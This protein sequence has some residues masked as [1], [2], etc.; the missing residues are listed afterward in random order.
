[1]TVSR[2][3]ETAPCLPEADTPGGRVRGAARQGAQAFLGIPYG[4]STAGEGRFCPP[5]PA[6][7]WAGT[8]EA[9]THGPSAPQLPNADYADAIMSWYGAIRDL[10]EDCLRLNVFTPACDTARR[11]V[12]VWLH[13]GGWTQ[14]ASTA[15]GFDG[16]ALAAAGDVVVVSLNHRLGVFGFLRLEDEDPRFADSGN[17]GMLDIVL[18]LEWVRDTISGFGGDPGNVTIFGQSGGGAKVAAL[19]A[20]PA[21]RGLF[22]KAIVQ[23]SS[24]S[25]RITGPEEAARNARDL[26]R[27]LGLE[28]ATG[29]AMQALP[30]E[31][32]LRATTQV[33]GVFR[34]VIDGRSFAGDQW[35]PGAPETARGIPLMAGCT[36]TEAAAYMRFDARNA[37]ISEE[38]LRLRLGRFLG[39]GPDLTLRLIAAYRE[40][41]QGAT[42]T[43]ILIAAATDQLFCRNTYAIARLQA[44]TGAPAYAYRFARPVAAGGGWLGAPHSAELPFI[45]GTTDAAALFV[46]TGPDIAP[47]TRMM[48]ATWAAFARNGSPANPALPE[49]RPY[50]APDRPVMVLAAEP[51]LRPDPGAGARAALEV[52]PIYEYGTSRANFAAD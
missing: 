46:G 14:F 2:S 32:I 13:G 12:M 50:G 45:F 47:M 3:R 36:A 40:G 1:M 17:A 25:R 44:E 38:S 7:P 24:G 33:P 52:L 5:R 9:V 42:P 18:A 20:M 23:S 37:D 31:R 11:P 27:A 10:S 15:P 51:A 48:M 21:A 35:F 26:A 49:W 16:A 22:H 19:M 6:A 43:Q 41:M 34:P 4:A 29:A 30:M 8:R 39:T 28:R